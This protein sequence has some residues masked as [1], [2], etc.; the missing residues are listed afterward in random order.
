MNNNYL[1]ILTFFFYSK[2]F[3]DNFF[4][5]VDVQNSKFERL[6]KEFVSIML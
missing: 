4:E 3:L 5:N 2:L 1:S 6:L